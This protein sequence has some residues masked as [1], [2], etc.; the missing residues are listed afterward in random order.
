MGSASGAV[1]VERRAATEE[2]LEA[3][4]RR[5]LSVHGYYDG[6]EIAR[7]LHTP[8]YGFELKEGGGQ[9]TCL[10]LLTKIFRENLKLE[11]GLVVEGGRTKLI[12]INTEPS[13]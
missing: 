3:A 12:V 6:D 4:L 9:L 11:L 1:K 8:A 10:A 5:I 2:E 7:I 13:A